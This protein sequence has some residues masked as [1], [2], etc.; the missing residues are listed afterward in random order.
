MENQ[1]LPNGGQDS[2]HHV[3]HARRL[4]VDKAQCWSSS[5]PRLD[6]DDGLG[7]PHCH[8][9]GTEGP[10]LCVDRAPVWTGARTVSKTFSMGSVSLP[11][12]K[13]W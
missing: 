11:Y 8:F 1:H 10:G 12:R 4:S 3:R 7:K 6:K 9:G 13:Q 5:E 2:L